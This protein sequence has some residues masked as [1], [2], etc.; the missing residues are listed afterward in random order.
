[1]GTG[2][3]YTW[4]DD[5]WNKIRNSKNKRNKNNWA[6]L[7]LDKISNTSNNM[8]KSHSNEVDIPSPPHPPFADNNLIFGTTPF[9]HY[10]KCEVKYSLFLPLSFL[11][12]LQEYWFEYEICF[13]DN[14]K[15][16]NPWEL[17]PVIWQP[18]QWNLF[19]QSC[20]FRTQGAQLTVER[21]SRTLHWKRD[22]K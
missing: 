12:S 10:Q 9:E 15:E 22:K 19:F 7:I 16:R 18:Y 17:G 3:S 8:H 2:F 6:Y 1:M 20:R 13:S 11:S 5:L 14:L 21:W 4:A